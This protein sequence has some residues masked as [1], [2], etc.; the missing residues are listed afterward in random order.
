M[1][2][3]RPKGCK[4]KKK[5]K[6]RDPSTC[7]NGGGN[8]KLGE[9]SPASAVR[10]IQKT[11]KKEN[12][13]RIIAESIQYWG[14]RQPKTNE[15]VAE[16]LNNYFLQCYETGQIPTVE[17]MCLALGV[18]RQSVNRWEHGIQCD[19]ERTEMIQKAKEILAAIDAKL[20]TEGKILPV[21]YIFRAKNYH[22][23]RDQQETIITPNNPLGDTLDN[24]RLAQKYLENTYGISDNQ[25]ELPPITVEEVK[26]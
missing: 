1:G 15:D 6:Q 16:C 22:G 5:R 18:T 10:N 4:D 20:V 26:K 7:N 9:I 11:E 12:I 23:M 25:P 17:D 13:Q 24:D 8:P 3:G 19:A 21:T 14:R 2:R